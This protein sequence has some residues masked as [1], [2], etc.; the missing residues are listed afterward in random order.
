MQLHS[1][2][3]HDNI[4]VCMGYNNCTMSLHLV[5]PVDGCR[6]VVVNPVEPPG[7]MPTIT[8]TNTLKLNTQKQIVSF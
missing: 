5:I 2:G 1:M 7:E 8:K 6:A 4:I 3:R